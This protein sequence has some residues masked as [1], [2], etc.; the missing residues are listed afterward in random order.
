MCQTTPSV[1]AWDEPFRRAFTTEFRCDI[2]V[3]FWILHDSQLQVDV[4]WAD[5]WASGTCCSRRPEL[6]WLSGW[7][8]MIFPSWVAALCVLQSCTPICMR[9]GRKCGG[10]SDIEDLKAYLHIHITSMFFLV[11]YRARL[12][13]GSFNDQ[14]L[15]RMANSPSVPWLKLEFEMF[16]SCDQ[17]HPSRYA[18]DSW[19][20]EVKSLTFVVEE[21]EVCQIS[22]QAIQIGGSVSG[23]VPNIIEVWLRK[24]KL[25]TSLCLCHCEAYLAEFGIIWYLVVVVI[26]HLVRSLSSQLHG[27]PA[28]FQSFKSFWKAWRVCLRETRSTGSKSRPVIWATK[29]DWIVEGNQ[30]EGCSWANPRNFVSF[31]REGGDT[32]SFETAK[33]QHGIPRVFGFVFVRPNAIAPDVTAVTSLRTQAFNLILSTLMSS[34]HTVLQVHQPSWGNS[35]PL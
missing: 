11:S 34:S 29:A 17:R 20:N 13:F 22:S 1:T 23:I 25:Q 15:D 2:A 32:A 24:C 4:G 6:L 9:C 5:H 26:M 18:A 16:Q 30:C 3:F 33:N 12:R 19:L 21:V 28:E 14:G 10:T 27:L 7:F 8:G 31:P 35:R